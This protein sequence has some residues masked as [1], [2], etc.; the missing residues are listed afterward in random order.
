MKKKKEIE[1][2]DKFKKKEELLKE[3]CNK[4]NIEYKNF[5]KLPGKQWT[6]LK[7]GM[8]GMI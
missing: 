4:L 5:N 1:K 3:E 2:V 8:I 6:N 7:N